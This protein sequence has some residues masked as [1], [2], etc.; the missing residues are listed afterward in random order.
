MDRWMGGWIFLTEQVPIW[1]EARQVT[2]KMH[3][4]WRGKWVLARARAG[5]II[6]RGLPSPFRG[7]H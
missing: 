6:F 1:A 3:F 5:L 7:W 2:P 4:I